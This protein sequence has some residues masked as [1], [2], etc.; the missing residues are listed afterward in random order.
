VLDIVIYRPPS[1]GGDRNFR[2]VIWIMTGSAIVHNPVFKAYF[3]KKKDEGQAPKK[4]IFAT[5]H[6]LLRTIHVL[7]SQ[8]T[9]FERK[10]ILLT[11]SSNRQWLS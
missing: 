3:Q 5:S 11:E 2:R 4:A 7:L 6:K 10:C 8:R 9:Y 1:Q